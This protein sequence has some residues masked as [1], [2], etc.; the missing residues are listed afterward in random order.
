MAI[1]ITKKE[2]ED[3]LFLTLNL[4]LSLNNVLFD[5]TTTNTLFTENDWVRF[6]SVFEEQIQPTLLFG[7]QLM[8]IP[9]LIPLWNNRP[10]PINTN[11]PHNFIDEGSEG[12]DGNIISQAILNNI[13]GE[14]DIA[15]DDLINGDIISNDL[16]D[17]ANSDD[18]F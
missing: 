9:P 13:I 6:C 18:D 3:N 17:G 12:D 16:T 1:K 5:F 4:Y 2:P 8:G 15:D 7:G 10:P 11:L 14:D